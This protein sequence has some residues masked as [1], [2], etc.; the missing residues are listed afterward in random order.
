MSEEAIPTE[1]IKTIINTLNSD[2]ITPEEQALGYYTR[3]KL[4][5]LS[6]WD[7]WLAGEKK[8]I[9]QFTMQ[10]MFGEPTS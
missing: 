9:D 2:A 5:N 10:G 8:Q 4:K 3:K 6:T 7:Q 1:V